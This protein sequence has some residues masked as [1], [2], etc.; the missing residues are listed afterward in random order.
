VVLAAD[1]VPWWFAGLFW[2]SLLALVAVVVRDVRR[3]GGVR[4][5]WEAVQA[6]TDQRAGAGPT[7][8]DERGVS[9]PESD[10]GR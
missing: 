9:G 6:A 7:D 5:V 1:L 4:R 8:E 3:A 10:P 2:L